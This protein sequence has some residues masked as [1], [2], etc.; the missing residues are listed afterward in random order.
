MIEDM[1]AQGIVQPSSSPWA[2]P[3]VLVPK[4]DGTARFYID[5]WCLNTV[6][7]KDVYP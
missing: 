3:V 4:K 7:R 6:S 5:Y 2:N 1:Q